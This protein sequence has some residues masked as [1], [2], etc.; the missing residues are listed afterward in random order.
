M[1][2]AVVSWVPAVLLAAFML[3]VVSG[4]RTFTALAVLFLT[5]G[6]ITGYILAVAAVAEYVGDLM[7]KAPSRTRPAGLV[8]RIVAGAIVGHFMVGPDG[9]IAIS[10]PAL[11][12]AGALVGAYGGVAVRL[13]A[14]KKIGPIPAALLEDV[15][16]IGLAF[17]AVTRAASGT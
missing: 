2:A 5:R 10:G 3:G 1:S 14:I 7:P 17:L 12:I 13:E 6:G 11:G 8:G 16:A 15:V 4:L 9:W